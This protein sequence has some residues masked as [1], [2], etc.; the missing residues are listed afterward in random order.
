[1][2]FD[3]KQI[4]Q[5][6]RELG[7]ALEV[8]RKAQGI[9]DDPNA[10]G[11][12]VIKE[13]LAMADA[14]EHET[15]VWRMVPG[16]SWHNEGDTPPDNWSGY[17]RTVVDNAGPV[18]EWHSDEGSAVFEAKRI[19]QVYSCRQPGYQRDEPLKVFVFSCRIATTI[20]ALNGRCSGYEIVGVYTHL[21][22]PKG[23]TG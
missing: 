20:D 5:N 23:V 6:A 1:M 9:L 7:Q 18:K 19:A 15:A 13:S 11:P 10:L 3:L 14:L 17:P 8:V 2:R 12:L 16:A 4:R 21:H 22:A